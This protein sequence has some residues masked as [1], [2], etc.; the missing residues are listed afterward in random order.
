MIKKSGL[1][2]LQPRLCLMQSFG[3]KLL[4]AL[5]RNTQTA[6]N[7]NSQKHMHMI[8]HDDISPHGI[9]G[10]F[11]S[12]GSFLESHMHFSIIQH[13]LTVKRAACHKI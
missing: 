10:T 9:A 6:I 7:S 3:N 2:D 12:N 5:N 4:P 1:P 13:M 8:R 11:Y